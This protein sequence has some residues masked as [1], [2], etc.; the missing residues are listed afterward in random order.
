M[1]YEEEN[2]HHRTF[3]FFNPSNHPFYQLEL[4]D[5]FVCEYALPWSPVVEPLDSPFIEPGFTAFLE[6]H[7]RVPSYSSFFSYD[8]ALR[9][10]F[11]RGDYGDLIKRL[12]L[13]RPSEEENENPNTTIN[14]NEIQ[15]ITAQNVEVNTPD[16][17]T[18]STI[19]HKAP[20]AES[21]ETITTSQNLSTANEPNKNYS[22]PTE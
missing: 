6:S 17:N 18:G 10:N 20:S 1:K 12:L 8:I 9:M 3:W 15:H 7:P 11:T 14:N 2:M 5:S 19:V 22:S 13:P 16:V 4:D 21:S